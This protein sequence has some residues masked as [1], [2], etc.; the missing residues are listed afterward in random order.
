MIHSTPIQ[1]ACLMW[2]TVKTKHIQS[3]R[4][5]NCNTTHTV[6]VHAAN[7]SCTS[8]RNNNATVGILDYF[9]CRQWVKLD[10]LEMNKE[11]RKK[12]TKE[13]D[14]ERWQSFYLLGVYSEPQVT[15]WRCLLSVS[16]F[17]SFVVCLLAWNSDHR[18]TKIF[19]ASVIRKVR[20]NTRNQF[21]I[22]KG[23]FFSIRTCLL[24]SYVN[25][26]ML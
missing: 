24:F 8:D 6:F 15:D 20:Q 10:G 22:L 18:A 11:E 4:Q 3:W 1:S 25:I 5:S 17:I 16:G 21:L 7:T 14:E 13:E 2:F 26:K 12:R 23:F 19:L 9:L